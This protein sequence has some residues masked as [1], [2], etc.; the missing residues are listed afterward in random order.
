MTA[1]IEVLAACG[2]AIA[3]ACGLTVGWQGGFK[4]GVAWAMRRK[5]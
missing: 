3:F 5:T 2:I 1:S 4:R